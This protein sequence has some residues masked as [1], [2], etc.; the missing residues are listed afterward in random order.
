LR[1]F[2]LV[3][4]TSLP[5]EAEVEGA[6]VAVAEARE[7]AG[8]EVRVVADEAAVAAV[9]DEAAVAEV[10]V[11]AVRER[12]V[13]GASRL[14]APAAEGHRDHARHKPGKRV[15]ALRLNRE[16]RVSAQRLNRG[17]RHKELAPRTRRS[18]RKA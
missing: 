14:G 6:A 15:S 9:A 3:R 8:A 13:E 16:V 12:P 11:S 17:A 18:A 7:A 5:P 10:A 2:C 1:L 4:L